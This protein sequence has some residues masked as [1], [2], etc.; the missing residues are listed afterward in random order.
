MYSADPYVSWTQT[1]SLPVTASRPQAP[2]LLQDIQ[3]PN[4]T[5]PFS[6]LV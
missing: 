6:L 1:S 3:A 2:L 5:D 4:G